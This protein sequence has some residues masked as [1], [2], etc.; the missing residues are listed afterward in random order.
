MMEQIR[1]SGES[2]FKSFIFILS[3]TEQLIHV[4]KKLLFW[5]VFCF[6]F[7]SIK[8]FQETRVILIFFLILSI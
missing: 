8:S 7:E 5:N 1:I 3:S 2:F 6:I 4:C